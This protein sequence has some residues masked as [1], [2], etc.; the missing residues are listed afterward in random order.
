[1]T[2]THFERSNARMALKTRND[3][4]NWA[5][6]HDRLVPQAWPNLQPTFRIAPGAKVFTIGSCFARNIEEHL[7]LLGFELPT[8]E[9]SAPEAE[10]GGLRRNGIL[11]KYTPATVCQE[12]EWAA[13]IYERGTG[14][15]ED[16]AKEMQFDTQDGQ[17]I[18]LHLGGFIPVSKDRFIERR[19][20][21]YDLYAHAF[22]A[23]LV[24]LTFGLTESWVDQNTGL[25]IHQAP[26]TRQLLRAATQYDFVN[27]DYEACLSYM[28]RTVQTLRRINPEISIIITVSPV[29]LN[30]TF[31]GRDVILANALSKS[32]LCAATGKLASEFKNLDY[33]PSYENATLSPKQDAF[34]PDLRHV[35]DGFVGKIVKQLI[36][37]YF[38]VP[39][40]L[41][42]LIQEAAVALGSN[43]S[44]DETN[45]FTALAQA[46]PA[47]KDLSDD[48]LI[49][50]LRS[51]WRLKDKKEIRRIGREIMTRNTRL[52]RHLRA[53]AHIFPRCGLD[54]DLRTYA[55]AVL[56][57][58]ASNPLALKWAE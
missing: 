3:T 44:P 4:A 43:L 36:K 48:Q 40:D 46:R 9:F 30:A 56:A 54:E 26:A 11:N 32:T 55:R 34:E 23:N 1:M 39:D 37:H 5:H 27:L 52:H 13:K 41:S 20:E 19:R 17:V 24:A 8:L 42:A 10:W 18:D 28:R 22:S 21:I 33:F 6:V 16:D 35:R 57:N 2:D 14:F 51:S 58:D 31:T 12:I 49:V 15:F 38:E 7:S 29:A 47:F 50:Y 45:A 53:V 25:H